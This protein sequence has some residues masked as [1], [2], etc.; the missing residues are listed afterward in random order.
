MSPIVEIGKADQG[1]LLHGQGGQCLCQTTAAFIGK[2]RLFRAG[3]GIGNQ[4]RIG[5]IDLRPALATEQN[6]SVCCGQ[7]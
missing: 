1:G 2:D 5:Q 3:R 7:W 4:G 6:R